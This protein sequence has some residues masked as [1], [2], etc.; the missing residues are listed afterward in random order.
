MKYYFFFYKDAKKFQVFSKQEVFELKTNKP[1]MFL[2]HFENR[3]ERVNLSSKILL[4]AAL[5]F[6][7]YADKVK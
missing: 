4:F 6:L 3:F 2:P 5:K 1:K 7:S